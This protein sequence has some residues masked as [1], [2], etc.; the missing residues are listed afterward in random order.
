[1]KSLLSQ[2]TDNMSRRHQ[3][4]QIYIYVENPHL[5][6]SYLRTGPSHGSIALV[7]FV[8]QTQPPRGLPSPFPALDRKCHFLHLIRLSR[9]RLPSELFIRC[10][11]YVAILVLASATR[12]YVSK[13]HGLW[14]CKWNAVHTVGR[15]RTTRT[16]L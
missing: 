16:S 2:P 1:M 9:P 14:L 10:V 5:H 6:V 15:A 12:S 8:V 7:L 13:R 3:K 4:V 11:E